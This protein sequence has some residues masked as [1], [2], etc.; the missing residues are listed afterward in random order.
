MGK[1]PFFSIIIST[2]DRPELFLQALNSVIR[3]SFSDKEI[4]VVI[5]GS[6]DSN[7]SRYRE[8]VARFPEV[9]F[10]ELPH[11]PNGHGQSYAMNYGVQNSS[12]QY[13][14]FLD[15]DDYWS[16]EIYLSRVFQSLVA[17]STPVDLHYS[18]QRAIYSN[19]VEQHVPVWIEDLIGRVQSQAEHVED[20]Y[21]VD[22]EFLLNSAGFAHL[23][24][25]VFERGF[26][27]SIG[28]MDET[29][30]Y[31]NDR[32]IYIRSLDKAKAILFSTRYIS[33][34]N[35]PDRKKK[36][37]MSTV[38]SDIEKKLFQMRVYDK[39]IS[40]C[41]NAKMVRFCSKSKV[42]ELKHAARILAQEGRYSSAAHFAKS[43][44]ISG[45]NL[46][47]LGYTGYLAIMSGLKSNSANESRPP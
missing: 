7:L 28:G 42:Y 10:L 13:L 44:L 41:Q 37:N 25:S 14:C 15:D 39:G 12:G 30:R 45:F 23:N 16:D 21:F 26:Y 8:F 35:I 5:D 19:G 43:A 27:D 17:S 29:I 32:D 20:C 36:S 33:V 47:W 6:S 38:S 40:L 31:E 1:L 2:R 18:N 24:C 34:H 11:R 3:Q 46:R 9:R 4:V 22:I